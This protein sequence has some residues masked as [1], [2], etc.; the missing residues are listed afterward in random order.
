MGVFYLLL[1]CPSTLLHETCDRH[2]MID[3]GTII[4]Q[5]ATLLSSKRA[6]AQDRL[7]AD[8]NI[9]FLCQNSNLG[10][11]SLWLI[12]VKINVWP[13]PIRHDPTRPHSTHDNEGL[14]FG[15]YSWPFWVPRGGLQGGTVWDGSSKLRSGSLKHCT[16]T[17]A[18]LPE[19]SGV[20][21]S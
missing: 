21:L 3:T 8:F 1:L 12:A 17:S 19:A 10:L 6:R 4:C 14:I 16:V 2:V 20:V 11:V 15:R 18:A 9:W 5:R 13:V 7:P